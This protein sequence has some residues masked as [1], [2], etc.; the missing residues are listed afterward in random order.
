MPTLCEAKLVKFGWRVRSNVVRSSIIEKWSSYILFYYR[1][2]TNFA[3]QYLI[4]TTLLQTIISKNFNSSTIL[5]RTTLLY[6]ILLHGPSKLCFTLRIFH[7]YS[8]FIYP[9]GYEHACIYNFA[10]IFT[11][12]LSTMFISPTVSS[13]I[14]AVALFSFLATLWYSTMK[15]FHPQ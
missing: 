4:L 6:T 3:S 13:S 15:Q 5:L 12:L 1:N 14:A 8:P 9:Y 11:R 10:C 7:L 2:F